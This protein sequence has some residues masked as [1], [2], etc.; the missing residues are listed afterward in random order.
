VAK[1]NDV[2]AEMGRK[3]TGILVGV[4]LYDTTWSAK[5]FYPTG[6]VQSSIG[7][8]ARILE[9]LTSSVLIHSPFSR[10]KNLPS[11]VLDTDTA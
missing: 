5:P 11:T 10:C 2:V 7:F 8:E 3:P 6:T 4:H 1:P 9:K